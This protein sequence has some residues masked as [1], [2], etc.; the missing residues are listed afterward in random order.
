[1]INVGSGPTAQDWCTFTIS[2]TEYL[3]VWEIE[4]G[5]RLRETYIIIHV[6]IR[7]IYTMNI[8]GASWSNNDLNCSKYGTDDCKH[9]K[10]V[11]LKHSQI[12]VYTQK[13]RHRQSK[14]KSNRTLV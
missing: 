4:I 10:R 8:I 11:D 1:M 6:E 3:K 9:Q 14:S 2:F 12:N 7:S 5:Y 13:Q